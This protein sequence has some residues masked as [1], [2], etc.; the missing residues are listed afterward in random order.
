VWKKPL[1]G[2]HHI[3]GHIYAN[4]IAREQDGSESLSHVT[5]HLSPTFPLLALVVSGGHTQLVLMREHFS[6]EIIGETKDD[7]AG[8]AFDKVARMLG[9][10]YPGGPAV[11]RKADAFRE[12]N[13]QFPIS[14]FQENSNDQ[15]SKTKRSHF[16][17]PMMESGD[18]DF[19]F[20][21]LKTA[22]L[23]YL[24]AHEAETSD[25]TFIAT[26]CHEFQEAVVDV[27]VEKT[28]RALLEY[29]PAAFTIA[30]GVSANVRLRERLATLLTSDFPDTA[31]LVPEFQYSLDNAAMIGS[32]AMYRFEQVTES[33]RAAL[34]SNALALEPDANLSL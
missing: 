6:Y 26:V 5:G 4:F 2:I 10:P 11:S 18:Y 33:D 7:A 12:R 19:S 17:R 27:L 24:K 29:R 15:D 14:N 1:L 30:G 16:P 22:V 23:Y 34:I 28:R 9:L 31:F 25:E 8:E 32:A 20:S 21:G 13:V 3:E